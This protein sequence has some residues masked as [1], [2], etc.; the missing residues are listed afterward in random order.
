MERRREHLV[1]VGVT[2][3]GAHAGPRHLASDIQ[4]VGHPVRHLVGQPSTGEGQVAQGG[5]AAQ[6]TSAVGAHT[7]V[8]CSR[9]T[10]MSSGMKPTGPCSAH[11]RYSG[12]SAQYWSWNQGG[13][14][15]ASLRSSALDVWNE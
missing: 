3:E 15:T 5:S 14:C 8:P 7:P 12:R 1:G 11:S 9:Y 10:D 6:S 13:K 4:V 2:H